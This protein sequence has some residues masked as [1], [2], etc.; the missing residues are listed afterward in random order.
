MVENLKCVKMWQ[1]VGVY[2]LFLVLD[3]RL[4]FLEQNNKLLMT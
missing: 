1:V 2:S 4:F 3:E